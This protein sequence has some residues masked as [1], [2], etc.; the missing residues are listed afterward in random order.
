[1]TSD[2]DKNKDIDQDNQEDIS[3]L[4][5]DLAAS[6]NLITISDQ[7]QEVIPAGHSNLSDI[8]A[9]SKQIAKMKEPRELSVQQLSDNKII[10]SAMGNR[11]IA[12]IY[13]DLRTKLLHVSKG[14]NFVTLITSVI[15][16]GGA[17]HVAL[18]LASSFAFDS[19]KTSLLVDCDLVNS[20][21]EKLLDTKCDIGLTDFI[22]DETINLEEIIYPTGI[23]RM[24]LIPV[25]KSKESNI[26]YFTSVRMRLLVD[27]IKRR[28]PDRYIFIDSPSIGNSA[29]TR[30]LADLCDFMILIIPYGEITEAKLHKILDSVDQTKIAGVIFNK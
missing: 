1:M 24:R 10:H 13:R 9:A 12:N 29:D 2:T 23:H 6:T 14:R 5:I 27:A 3:G 20:N 28:Y 22:V 7:Q 17:S 30:I 8:A 16:G 11:E 18:N 26:E 4:D 21:V 19:T 25:G 15:E